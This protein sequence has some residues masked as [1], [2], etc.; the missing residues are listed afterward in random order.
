MAHQWTAQ[1]TPVRHSTVIENH[2]FTHFSGVPSLIKDS[3]L[4]I[5]TLSVLLGKKIMERSKLLVSSFAS[6]LLVH[7]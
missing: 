2:Q 5:W 4:L 6:C 1:S 3:F 7:T